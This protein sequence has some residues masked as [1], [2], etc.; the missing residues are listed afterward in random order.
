MAMSKQPLRG[1]E[2]RAGNQ[3]AAL[4]S[5]ALRRACIFTGTAAMTGAGCYEMYEVLEVGGV[6]M[7]E[8]T[9]LFLFVPL[10]AWIAFS[11]PR[12]SLSRNTDTAQQILKLDFGPERIKGWTKEDGR[13]E[14]RLICF[15][16]PDHRLIL[17]V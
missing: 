5:V 2:S 10:F 9:V 1:F 11:S 6:T 12:L 3:S 17:I 15:F 8:W 7:L 14:A 16:Q 4:E 13:I